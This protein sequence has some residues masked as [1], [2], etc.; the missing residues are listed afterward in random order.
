M[1]H[2]D[3]DFTDFVKNTT[4]ESKKLTYVVV[5][6]IDFTDF[7]VSQKIQKW[8]FKYFHPVSGSILL[9]WKHI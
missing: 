8:K 3:K 7:R 2:F 5:S 1:W 9:S 4:K 6:G